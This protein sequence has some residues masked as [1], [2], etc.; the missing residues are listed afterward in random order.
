MFLF[1]LCR[2]LLLI[3]I[4]ATGPSTRGKFWAF[5][6]CGNHP[7][8]FASY[9]FIRGRVLLVFDVEAYVGCLAS[10]RVLLGM[11]A[12]LSCVSC[13]AF[14]PAPGPELPSR[15][16]VARILLRER[17]S[18]F[19]KRFGLLDHMILYCGAPPLCSSTLGELRPWAHFLALPV[20][21]L[22]C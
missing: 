11:A 15:C 6:S 12:V 19:G 21:A 10:V 18:R 4:G 3:P 14:V 1:V 16:L 20:P 7:Q 17:S 22:L 8:L 2:F 13:P 9:C 5:V